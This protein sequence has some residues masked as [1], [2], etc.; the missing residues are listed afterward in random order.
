MSCTAYLMIVEAGTDGV[1]L[2]TVDGVSSLPRV[3]AW[4][5]RTETL[6]RLLAGRDAHGAPTG[7]PWH[8]VLPG[9]TVLASLAHQGRDDEQGDD[10]DMLFLCEP[11]SGATLDG[12]GLARWTG[13]DDDLVD[14]PD[15]FATAMRAAYDI[16]CGSG[17]EHGI[18]WPRSSLPGFTRALAR[19]LAR[20]L[21]SDPAAALHATLPRAGVPA[22]ATDLTQLQGW[23][24]SSVWCND[25]VVVKVTNPN[26]PREPDINRFL[27]GVAPH[28]VEEVIAS[29]MLTD[30]PSQPA[31]WMLQRR[32]RP[33]TAD[34]P[35]TAGPW[36]GSEP[37][38]DDRARLLRLR[39]LTVAALAELQ[40]TLADDPGA[41][42]AAGADDRSI[43]AVTAQL[44]ELWD[45]PELAATLEPNE[46]DALPA[47][48]T[49]L[50]GRLADLAALAPVPLM[51]HGDLHLGNVVDVG[52]GSV[53]IIDWTDAAM[54]WPGVDV[55]ALLP[56]TSQ[57]EEREAVLTAYERAIGP[58]HARAVRP[59][60][61]LA[62]LF[63]ALSY[64]KIDAFLPAS[65]RWHFHGTITRMVRHLMKLAA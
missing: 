58:D 16:A 30:G 62:V 40:L 53:R 23:C 54:S 18:P 48:D 60:C 22:R 52:D 17:T 26:W 35:V 11:A 64:T 41:P 20:A 13:S 6:G 56:P 31:P 3:D 38:P 25:E 4:D 28:L 45:A 44:Q 51:T 47:L 39:L 5:G 12:L 10:G 21:A 34:R 36:Q 49:Y 24:L 2:S 27:H 46:K 33:R 29:G 55:R 65:T 9:L 1:A 43:E 37:A 57:P 42:R 8:P 61:E 50:R 59:G 63:Y 15:G 14:L 19:E 7:T 32:A